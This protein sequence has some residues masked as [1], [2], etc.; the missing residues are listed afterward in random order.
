VIAT[1]PAYHDHP[2]QRLLLN[3]PD[4]THRGADR[5]EPATR[6]LGLVAGRFDQVL[7]DNP[8]VGRSPE[9]APVTERR[10]GSG[11]GGTSPEPLPALA[12]P[13]R[14]MIAKPGSILLADG[15]Q[16]VTS[17]KALT[18]DRDRSR[19]AADGSPRTAQQQRLRRCAEA[20]RA[21][22]GPLLVA[23]GWAP[24]VRFAT[25][26]LLEGTGFEPSVPPFQ[27]GVRDTRLCIPGV[28]QCRSRGAQ[29]PQ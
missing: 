29:F 4:T 18:A 12:W 26:S 14:T 22:E 7:C 15:Q 10:S 19:G 16:D 2:P 23:L 3:L 1:S 17:P 9:P 25:D 28:R 6:I 8:A 24:K 13:G 21:N 20:C 11:F 27:S 5:P